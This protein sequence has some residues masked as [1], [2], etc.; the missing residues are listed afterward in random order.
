MKKN[1]ARKAL[2]ERPEL[3]WPEEILGP[4]PEERKSADPNKLKEAIQKDIESADDFSELDV[5]VR[6]FLK[7]EDQIRKKRR[8]QKLAAMAAAGISPETASTSRASV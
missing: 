5:S 3:V 8:E 2:F 6:Q 7:I 1:E 4:E